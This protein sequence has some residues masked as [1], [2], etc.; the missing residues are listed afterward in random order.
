MSKPVKYYYDLLSQPSRAMLIFL[1]VAKIPFE[2]APVALRK[3]EHLTEEFKTE[4]NRFQKVPCI[5][6]NGF[7]LSES[8]AIVRYLAS[9]HN[10]PD[11]WYPTDAKKQ[12]QV[13]EYLE[14]QHNNTRISCALYFQLLWLKPLM[15]GKKPTPEAVA[16]HQKRVEDTLNVIENVW[17][18]KTP[19][20]AGNEVT[21]ADIWAA[22]EIEQL[23]LTPYDFRKGR[24][25][26]SAWM[27]KVRAATNPHY[28]EAHQIL[29]R[30]S[31]KTAKL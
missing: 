11:N 15:T 21:V 17:L 4:V 12:A 1:K 3:A 25:R 5:N 29:K 10:I 2:S 22:C 20:L 31:E 19:F 27:D 9:K 23:I 7:K 8:V 13:D 14:W 26:L 24:P 6:D 28:D 30:I 16:E 18:A